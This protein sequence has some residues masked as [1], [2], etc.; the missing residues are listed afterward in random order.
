MKLAEYTNPPTS[1]RSHSTKPSDLEYT[2]SLEVCD[3]DKEYQRL[4]M[5]GVKF[6]VIHEN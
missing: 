4:I 5:I 6:L 1:D 2:Y 3:M